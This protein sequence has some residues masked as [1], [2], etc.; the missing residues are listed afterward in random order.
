M[1]GVGERLPR[2]RV[3]ARRAAQACAAAQKKPWA[4]AGE[5][6]EERWSRDS[7]KAREQA[8][9]TARIRVD[10]RGSA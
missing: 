9:A 6:A 7:G 2:A 5:L 1:R 4:S 8:F 10:F 3:G